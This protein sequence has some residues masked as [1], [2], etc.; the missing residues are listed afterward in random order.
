MYGDLDAPVLAAVTTRDKAATT[1]QR[2]GND[3]A[4]TVRPSSLRAIACDR[5]PALCRARLLGCDDVKLAEVGRG[6]CQF[7]V[8]LYRKAVPGPALGDIGQ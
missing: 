4:T 1:A 8:R 7:K 2:W 3:G 6:A 5:L